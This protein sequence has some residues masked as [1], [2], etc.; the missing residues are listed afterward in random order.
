MIIPHTD[1][2]DPV[3]PLPHGTRR[4]TQMKMTLIIMIDQ[5]LIEEVMRQ[6]KI[7]NPVLCQIHLI[8]CANGT[9]NFQALVTNIQTLF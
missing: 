1:L 5:E 6:G 8:P 9:F 3:S 4:G 7:T 2:D